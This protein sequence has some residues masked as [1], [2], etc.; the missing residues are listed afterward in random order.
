MQRENTRFKLGMGQMLVE[1]GEA[2]RNLQRAVQMIQ[3][4]AE[5][6]CAMVVLPE[7]LDLGWTDPSARTL[8]QPIP[9]PRSAVLAQAAQQTQTYVVAGLTELA[10]ERIYN[11]AVLISPEAEILL[12]HRKINIMEIAR[13]LYTTGDSLVVTHTPLG[14]IGV[15]ICADNFPNASVLAIRW[16]AWA[17][18]FCS[19]PAPG[20]CPLTMITVRNPMGNFGKRHTPLWPNSTI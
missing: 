17:R 15:N 9:G 7:C 20:P 10:G 4:A 18:S 8:A 16:P 14:T 19:P 6:G 2:N 12:K 13:D 3:Q 11:A 5:Q 1:G